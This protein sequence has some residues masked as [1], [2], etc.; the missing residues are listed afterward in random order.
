MVTLRE[1]DW[2]NESFHGER[3]QFDDKYNGVTLMSSDED[4]LI[5]RPPTQL[6]QINL[7]SQSYMSVA[8]ASSFC[9]CIYMISLAIYV[10]MKLIIP[11]LLVLLVRYIAMTNIKYMEL[12]KLLRKQQ[13][14]FH[15]IHETQYGA[16]NN[17]RQKETILARDFALT[18]ADDA[19]LGSSRDVCNTISYDKSS[20]EQKA[21]IKLNSSEE[22]DERI[23]RCR[24]DR[25]MK[26]DY[27]VETS[28]VQCRLNDKTNISIDHEETDE[29]MNGVQITTA[30]LVGV[31]TAAGAFCV[32][33]IAK[34][35]S[36]VLIRIR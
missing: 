7:E 4:V 15:K 36:Q 13:R 5:Q 31:A 26:N 8:Q 28:A 19:S 9:F 24:S 3:T 25:V 29:L 34:H 27:F 12:L 17:T 6:N 21:L 11:I 18:E 33:F 16:E 22:S 1:I 20:L 35:K 10:I 23:N 30:A 14:P 2:N 32:G